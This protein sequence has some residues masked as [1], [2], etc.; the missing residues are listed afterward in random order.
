M[1]VTDI[2]A[3]FGANVAEDL[4]TKFLDTNFIRLGVAELFLG[5]FSQ[6][7]CE[8]GTLFSVREEDMQEHIE[9]VMIFN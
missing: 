4:C 7:F 2:E 9:K 1:L 8:H 3:E 5:V 6:A